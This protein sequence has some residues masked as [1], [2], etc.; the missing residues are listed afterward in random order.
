MALDQMAQE[1]VA[2]M[3]LDQMAQESVAAKASV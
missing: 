3:V 1:S 2:A